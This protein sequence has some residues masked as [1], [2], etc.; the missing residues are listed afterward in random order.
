MAP[1]N[2]PPGDGHPTVSLVVPFHDT[3]A[4]LDV[5]LAALERVR[6]APSDEIVIADN[7]PAGIATSRALP[8]PVR[9]VPAHGEASC[10]RARNAGAAASR[11]EW[12]LFVDA[13]CR[14]DP[15]LVE[16][17]RAEPLAADCGIV[18]G[19]VRADPAQRSLAA[20]WARTR[21]L[22]D[23]RFTLA[24]PFMPNPVGA[25]HLVRRAT[26]Q[27]LGGYFEGI[28][29][30]EDIDF[31]WRAQR[32]GWTLAYRPQ[33]RV[34]HTHRARIGGLLRQAR[35]H[36]GGDGWVRRRWDL[37]PAPV[38]AVRAVVRAAL[39][40][41]VFLATGQLGRARLK[42]LDGAVAVV[43]LRGARAS[44]RAARPETSRGEGR[45]IQLWCDAFPVLSET[46]VVGEARALAALGHAVE[47]VAWRRPKRPALGAHD[48]DARWIEDDTPGERRRA[49]LSLVL[50]HP[51]RCA[52]DLARRPKWRRQEYVAPLRVLAPAILAVGP[53]RRAVLHAHFAKGAA[54]NAMRAARIA[55]VPWTLTAH[56]YDIYAEPANL[57]VKLRD[58][59]LV[60]SGCDRTVD[61]LRG[62]AGPRRDRVVKVVMGVDAERFHRR[63]PAAGGRTVLAVGRLVEKKGF[64]HLLRAAALPE[65]RSVA[66]RV[67]I[68]GDGP[69]RAELERL[70]RELRLDA[71]VELRGACEPDEVR[72]LLEDCTVLAVPSVLAADGDRESMP[73]VAKE[74]LAM[75]VPVV[76]S[77]LMGLPEVV[78]PGW[79]RLVP[80]GDSAAL[81]AAL[82]ELLLLDV[83]TRAEMGR[84]GREFVIEFA[85][86]HRETAR[87]SQLLT[88]ATEAGAPPRGDEA[89]PR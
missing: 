50:G 2:A 1:D 43:R 84:A 55:G 16:A 62:I 38:Q 15:G 32:A 67:V 49:L 22:L 17:Y 77:D 42:L 47:V 64:E 14:P 88:R 58:A 78:R 63:R 13:D 74:A 9:A 29:S 69:L 19:A 41:P 10:A 56:A 40:A 35:H 3:A 21:R 12:L 66:E 20:T 52:A 68:A 46:F 11:G 60:T 25:N 45:P 24:H 76:C 72:M 28:T 59:A 27:Q 70:V 86:V 51:L 85:D 71:L 4:Q 48:V 79:G 82:R 65:L 30:G 26:W 36:A 18:A 7:T 6:L 81:A 39:A 31:S 34:A 44:I 53:A 83:A 57:A 33:A 54:L 87:L 37:P 75:E 5:L 23:E 8:P 61:H 73:L 80:P 89:I